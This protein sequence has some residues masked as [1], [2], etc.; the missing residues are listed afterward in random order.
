MYFCKQFLLRVDVLPDSR[1]WY[2]VVSGGE[3]SVH[4]PVLLPSFSHLVPLPHPPVLA[5]ALSS[6][7]RAALIWPLVC[8]ATAASAILCFCEWTRDR[9]P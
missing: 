2:V 3:R 6:P 1:A 9:T 5:S 7:T 4:P 8:G